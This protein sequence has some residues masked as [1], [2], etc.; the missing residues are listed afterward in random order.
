MKVY[1]EHVLLTNFLIDFSIL[2]IIS[3]IMYSK[4]NLKRI[5]LS[6][7]FGS[8]SCLI[9]PLC[10]TTLITNLL[11]FLSAIIMLQILNIKKNFQNA[12]ELKSAFI[13][14]IVGM[15]INNICRFSSNS[16]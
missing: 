13:T 8:L 14:S 4:P 3:K 15:C 9:L 11:K 2:I 16:F 5:I 6:S 12:K 7:L 10:T 1:I